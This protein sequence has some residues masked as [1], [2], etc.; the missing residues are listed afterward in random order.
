[1]FSAEKIFLFEGLSRSEREAILKELPSAVVYRKGEQIYSANGR[2]TAMGILLSGRASAVC[3]NIIKRTFTAGD[4]FGVAALFGKGESYDSR[5]VAKSDCTVQFINEQTLREIFSRY[6]QT[7]LNYIA[8]LSSRVR[9]LNKKIDQ[10][11]SP[12]AASK[13]QSF[14]ESN[15]GDDGTVTLQSMST[16]SRL[17]GV[18]RT[19][20]YRA[21]DELEK[22]GRI[23]RNNNTIRVN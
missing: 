1:M 14:L 11:S 15:K 17:V 2:D 12:D 3:E 6:P 5:I 18:G 9:F 7:A 10:L 22:E 16:L 19:S 21:L 4:V 23:T 8:F 20:L 13:L